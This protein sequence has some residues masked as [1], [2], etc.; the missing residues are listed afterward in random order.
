[1]IYSQLDVRKETYTPNVLEHLQSQLAVLMYWSAGSGV[2]AAS[3]EERRGRVS[4]LISGGGPTSQPSTAD[5][6]NTTS[7]TAG[8]LNSGAPNLPTCDSGCVKY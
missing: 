3:D 8:E 7:D 5:V 4:R 1:M 6:A 2:S